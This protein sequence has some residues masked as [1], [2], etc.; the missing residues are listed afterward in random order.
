KNTLCL[1][2]QN[3]LNEWVDQVPTQ[4]MFLKNSFLG[5]YSSDNW[6]ASFRGSDQFPDVYLGRVSTRTAVLA[7]GVHDKI[8]HYE[9]TPPPGTWK[10][11]GLLLAG[12][13]KPEN[14]QEPGEFE[15]V[16]D[17]LAAAYFSTAPYSVP[18]PP[19]YFGRAPWNSTDA[20]KFKT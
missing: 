6:I 1:S 15:S 13:G 2:G 17:N 14:P 12:D 7:A 11:R 3:C 4:I 19:M 9:Q 20:A 10:G 18:S 5:Y 8:R 16:Q